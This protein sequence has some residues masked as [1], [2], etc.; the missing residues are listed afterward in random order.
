MSLETRIVAKHIYDNRQNTTNV[1]VP[2]GYRPAWTDDRLNPQRAEHTLRPP[3]ALSTFTPPQGYRKVDREDD[4]LNPNRGLRT[5]QGDTATNQIWTDT[6]PRELRPV[7]TNPRTIT[8][9]HPDRAYVNTA[10]G[11]AQTYRLS[12]RNAPGSAA[13]ATVEARAKPSYVRVATFGSDAEARKAAKALA[14][15]GLPVRLG[16]IKRRSG[17]VRVVLAGPYSDRDQAAST[18][19]R[20]RAAGYGGASLTR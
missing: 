7:A 16:T 10:E 6:I 13:P 18:L 17:D 8:V 2:N 15:Q 12:S 1:S 20:L 5:A 9:T 11:G 19:N 3:I 4:R 14:G